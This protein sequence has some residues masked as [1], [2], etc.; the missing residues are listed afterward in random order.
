MREKYFEVEKVGQAVAALETLPDLAV[1]RISKKNA[2][3]Q[4]KIAVKSLEKKGY[5][6]TEIFE[7]INKYLKGITKKDIDTLLMKRK[8]TKKKSTPDTLDTL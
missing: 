6:N 1:T 4:L 7:E 8:S 2:L 3:M 5:T